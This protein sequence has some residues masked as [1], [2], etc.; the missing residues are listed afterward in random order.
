MNNN[1]QEIKHLELKRAKVP[2][3]ICLKLAL[4]NMWKKKFRYLIMFIICS[5]ALTFLSFTI[6]LNGQIVTQNVHTMISNG[7]R[8]TDIYEHVPASK[9]EIKQN[10]YNKYNYRSLQ[11][12]NYD[13]IK[14]KVNNITLHEYTNVNIDYAGVKKENANYLYTGI[15]NTIIRFDETNNYDLICG[16]LPR[17]DTKEILITDYLVSA[18]DYFAIYPGNH[19]IYD[20]LNI[21]LNLNQEKDYVVVGIIKTNYDQWTKFSN[22]ESV[23]VSD[24]ENYSY[25][26]DSLFFNSV[27][28][29]EKYFEVEKIT[30]TNTLL[31]S[32][33]SGSQSQITGNWKIEAL[34][35][36][37]YINGSHTG[38]VEDN[39]VIGLTTDSPKLTGY[40]SWQPSTYSYRTT[41]FGHQAENEDEIVI[42]YTWIQSLYG[43]DWSIDNTSQ[44]SWDYEVREHINAFN[45]IKNSKI[46]ITLTDPNNSDLNYIHEFTIVGINSSSNTYYGSYSGTRVCGVTASDFKNVY[47]SFI[48]N[49]QNILVELP[50]NPQKAE[51]LFNDAYRNGYVI[52]I[53]AY[54]QDIELY[55]VDPFISLMSK[56]GLFIFAAFTM[57]LIWT[58]ISI[59]IVDSKKEIGIL[60]SIGLSGG[61]V[62]LIFIIQTASVILLSYFVGVFLAY[63]LIPIYNSGIM[64]AYHKI[65]LYMY[66]FTYRTPLF[67]AIF[68]VL[69]TFISTIIPLIKILSHKIIDVINERDN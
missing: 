50:N 27:I 66:T 67:L 16:R 56:A 44:G 68:I 7:Y 33:R 64:D 20:Y 51:A 3:R 54:R 31:F 41:F 53:F 47:S 30:D 49:T 1:N 24:K 59:E 55:N 48:T 61:K 29:N 69:M 28:I 65:I 6:E 46:R 18:F 15:I 39:A 63:R 45:A 9:L 52:D 14:E 21:H 10:E 40:R 8:F 37:V 25:L 5:L 11:G 32:N 36:N 26:Y 43:F 23:D 4:K 22:I 19:T 17:K 42:P 13:T 58:I 2:L 60:R 35:K 34:N 38:V 62:A 57:G 12:S